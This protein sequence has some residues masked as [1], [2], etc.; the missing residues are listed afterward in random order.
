MLMKFLA[1][2]RRDTVYGLLPAAEHGNPEDH[3]RAPLLRTERPSAGSTHGATDQ[4]EVD[5]DK[6]AAL[7]LCADALNAY[8]RR[9]RR[10]STALS[11]GLLD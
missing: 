11:L 7:E 6:R 5:S 1:C 4:Y 9:G 3:L 10:K 8:F 2:I